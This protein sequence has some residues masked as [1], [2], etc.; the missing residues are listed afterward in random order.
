MKKVAPLSVE[1]AF[2]IWS[3]F[4]SIVSLRDVMGLVSLH[5]SSTW[6]HEVS[7][8]YLFRGSQSNIVG[9]NLVKVMFSIFLTLH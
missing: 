9:V 4:L 1:N 6:L 8:L 7:R 2:Y 5:F 3:I